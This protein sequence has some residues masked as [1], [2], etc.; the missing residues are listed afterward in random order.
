ML[1]PSSYQ[2]NQSL[3][4]KHYLE[5]QLIVLQFNCNGI[6]SRLSELKLYIYAKKPEVV[7]LS[8]TWLKKHQPKFIGYDAVWKNRVGAEKGGLGI[9]IRRDIM[10]REK[11]LNAKLHFSGVQ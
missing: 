6:S 10:Y 3:K 11:V 9:L 5:K 7:C 8:E 4:R 1:N 2:I